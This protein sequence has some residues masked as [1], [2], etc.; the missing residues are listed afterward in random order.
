MKKRMIAMLLTF[1][2]I[3]GA[4]PCEKPAN[5]YGDGEEQVVEN[6]ISNAQ[7][8]LS[9]KSYTYDGYSHIPYVTVT[10]NGQEL[11][12]NSDYEVDCYN[13]VDAG[14]ASIYVYGIGDYS[15]E[16]YASFKIKRKKIKSL[17]LFQTQYTYNGKV[18]KPGVYTSDWVRLTRGKDY[19]LKKKTNC[20]KVGKH[21][22]VYKM[23]GNYSGTV[24]KTFKV[25]PK[26]P[27]RLKM[28]RRT[29]KS[30]R[31]SWKKVPGTT[32]YRVQWYDNKARKMKTKKVKGTS[33][34]MT[35]KS[36]DCSFYTYVA[37]VKVI[38]KKKYISN[39][40][41]K[42]C[43]TK[44]K[45]PKFKVRSDFGKFSVEMKEYGKYQIQWCYN[46]K[47][48]NW[49][50][51]EYHGDFQYHTVYD[52]GSNTTWWVRVRQYFYDEKNVLHMGKW[53]KKK[54]AKVY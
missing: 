4:A 22:V 45:K 19:T 7:I 54:K 5:A 11:T 28:S 3:L 8:T 37:A 31:L 36:Y 41:Y 39:D 51:N 30:V 10:F 52:L 33:T 43:Y 35:N 12:E 9:E 26:R 14:T 34:K 16:A 27:T 25:V 23:K 47:F 53:S 24:T 17:R 40:A 32:Y 1:G 2:M 50:V 42:L 21:K 44:P 29:T 13:N 46:K 48:K 49:Y 20:K 38:K 15:G 18:K 6:D